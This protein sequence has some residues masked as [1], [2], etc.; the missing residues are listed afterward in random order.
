MEAWILYELTYFIH[1]IHANNKMLNFMGFGSG[2][3][4][5]LHSHRVRAAQRLRILA[6]GSPS[7]PAGKG[8]TH[9]C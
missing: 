9:G 3:A 5:F 8:G 7:G 2:V 1:K 4:H 6:G